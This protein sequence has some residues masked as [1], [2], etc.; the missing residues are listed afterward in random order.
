MPAS[1][2]LKTSESRESVET[3][4][5]VEVEAAMCQE[6]QGVHISPI[7]FSGGF[8]EVDDEVQYG[9]VVKCSHIK[10]SAFAFSPSGELLTPARRSA[11]GPRGT[12]VKS[13]EDGLDDLCSL[14][15]PSC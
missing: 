7:C 11:K 13:A 8:E 10:K 1:K 15:Q 2:A 14:S 4:W 12:G 5:K 6:G 3:S 9:F